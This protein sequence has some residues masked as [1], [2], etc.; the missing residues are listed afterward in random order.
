[1]TYTLTRNRWRKLAFVCAVSV[2]A[3]GCTTNEPT[4]QK[5][6]STPPVPPI[7]STTQPPL[8]PAEAAKKE[9]IA[10]YLG[11]WQEMEKRYAD[12]TGKAGDLK[13]YATSE[14]LRNAELDAKRAHDRNK[15]HSGQVMVD[16]PTATKANLN[17]QIPY[18]ELSSCLDITK[19]QV[20][21][22]DTK[23][24]ATLPSNRLTRLVIASTV[25]RWPEGWRVTRDKPQGKSC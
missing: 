9:A 16:N 20:V 23:E 18:V 19:W 7:P 14:A 1:M 21:D 11:Y 24:P 22:A 3:V 12:K 2:L 8:D 10:T 25:E 6:P 5:P 4:S 15:I 17:R 13:R